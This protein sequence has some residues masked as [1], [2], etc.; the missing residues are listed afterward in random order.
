MDITDLLGE[1]FFW[2]FAGIFLLMFL[3][4]LIPL[5]MLQILFSDNI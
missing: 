1:I 4:I 2:C 5:M 3:P